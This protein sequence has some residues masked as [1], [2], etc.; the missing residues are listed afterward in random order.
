[1]TRTYP[2]PTGLY[3]AA[4]LGGAFAAF[5]GLIGLSQQDPVVVGFCLIGLAL[6]GSIAYFA[7][8]IAEANNRRWWLSL[9]V[10]LAVLIAIAGGLTSL[11]GYSPAVL[12]LVAAFVR[13]RA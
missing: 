3:L 12:A 6:Y 5:I 10:L 8:T 2:R 1:M 11:I 4:I 9:I 13:R 7:P